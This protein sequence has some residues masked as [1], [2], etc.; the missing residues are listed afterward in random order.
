MLSRDDQ[1]PL[2]HGDE[3]PLDP[4]ATTRVAG[5]VDRPELSVLPCQFDQGAAQGAG[6]LART[7]ADWI[8]ANGSAVVPPVVLWWSAHRYHHMP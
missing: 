4:R 8:Y 6:E 7:A 2:P 1:T 5:R 3:P